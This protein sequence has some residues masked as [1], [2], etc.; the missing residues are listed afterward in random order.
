MSTSEAAAAGPYDLSPGEAAKRL[1]VS[2]VSVKR[3]AADGTLPGIRLPGG[4]LRFS[5]Q[6]LDDFIVRHAARK[7]TS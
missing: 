5:Q 3:W 6:D 7:A 2:I 1:G 4:W